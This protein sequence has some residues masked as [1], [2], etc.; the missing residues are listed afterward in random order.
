V[1]QPR[2]PV[3]TRSPLSAQGKVNT[4]DFV[5]GVNRARSGDGTVDAAAH[6]REDSHVSRVRG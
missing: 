2:D 4:Y 6:R 3:R 5:P 1:Q